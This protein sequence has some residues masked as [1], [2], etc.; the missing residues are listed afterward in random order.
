MPPVFNLSTLDKTALD[1]IDALIK[2]E[3]GKDSEKTHKMSCGHFFQKKTL[4]ES[5]SNQIQ[6]GSNTI[7]CPSIINNIKCDREWDE[8]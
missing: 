2:K 7:K 6:C 8:K 5:I 1:K 4:R 3:K